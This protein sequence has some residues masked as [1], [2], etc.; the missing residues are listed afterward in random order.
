MQ[1][2]EVALLVELVCV[3]IEVGEDGHQ[4]RDGFTVDL[5]LMRLEW[6]YHGG[7]TRSPALATSLAD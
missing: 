7:G 6:L 1:F 4:L 5:H 2:E 3:R